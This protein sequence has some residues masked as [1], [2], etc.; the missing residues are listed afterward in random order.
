MHRRTNHPERQSAARRGAFTL[1][2]VLVVIVIAT[3]LISLS[4][5]AYQNLIESSEQS[6]AVN[7]LQ[8]AVRSAQDIALERGGDSDGAVVFLHDGA[9]RV[10]MVPAVKIGEYENP[11]QP[12]GGGGGG[13]NFINPSP[14]GVDTVRVEVFAPTETGREIQ[15]PRLWSVRGYAV[16]G[17]LNDRMTPSRP[18]DNPD[19]KIAAVWY[20]SPIYGG[21]DVTDPIRRE[22]HWVFP[23]TGFYARDAQYEGGG[24][25]GDIAG[26]PQNQR[27]PRQ[28][29]MIRFDGRTGQLVRD[30]TP[31]IFIDPRPS[32]ER[33]YGDP[34][35]PDDAWKRIDLSISAKQ[36]AL[37]VLQFPDP[38]GDGDAWARADESER[39][40]LIGNASHDTV[41]VKSV[42]RLAL[43]NEEELAQDIGAKGLNATG[44]LYLPYDQ[45]D[46]G[47]EIGFDD[48]IWRGDFPGIDEV[49]DRINAWIEGNTNNEDN[50]DRILFDAEDPSVSDQPKARLYLIQPYSAELT[51]VLR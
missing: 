36:W 43:Y 38:D 27:T 44:T 17:S 11:V 5:P 41:F 8:N 25:D 32:R 37:R 21:D 12:I 35:D 48:A 31:A 39:T 50:E 20:N 33:P 15:L 46:S 9:G 10:S 2:E 28:S 45:A 34:P 24:T 23:E 6:L 42:T 30:T 3:I 4:V 13:G 40:K 18:S 16:P 7:A 14:I 49:R 29:F 47:S 19:E 22:A 26:N 51:E 1:V